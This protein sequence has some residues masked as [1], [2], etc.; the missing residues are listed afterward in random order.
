MI[1]QTV[2]DVKNKFDRLFPQGVD[3]RHHYEQYRITPPYS[4]NDS[5]LPPYEFPKTGFNTLDYSAGITTRTWRVMSCP[6]TIV[7]FLDLPTTMACA[8]ISQPVSG[9]F[10]SIGYPPASYLIGNWVV[11]GAVAG[12]G[13]YWYIGDLAGVHYF[14]IPSGCVLTAD[15]IPDFF[16]WPG[17]YVFAKH[18]FG[19]T[20]DNLGMVINSWD[21]SFRY[22]R[23]SSYSNSSA[24]VS[25]GIVGIYVPSML[26]DTRQNGVSSVASL[27]WDTY[28]SNHL[29]EPQFGLF[30]VPVM[31]RDELFSQNVAGNNLGQFDGYLLT[32]KNSASN[33]S[34]SYTLTAI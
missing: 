11:A 1:F 17:N 15:V 33:F 18:F 34:P 12:T 22:G 2:D 21:G 26:S 24:D 20:Q 4:F 13:L 14:F 27:R 10:T 7:G 29:N 5:V 28:T 8:S 3:V 25:G 23:L 6:G 16:D 32:P 31:M 30:S 19:T 9:Y